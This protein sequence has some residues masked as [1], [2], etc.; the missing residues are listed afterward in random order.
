GIKLDSPKDITVSATGKVSITAT[1]GIEVGSQA[2]LKLSGLNV[3]AEAD[4][5]FVGKGNATAEVS[6]SGQTTV[7]GALVMIN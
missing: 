3:N 5:G 2:D 7:K 4:V 1:T 6:S